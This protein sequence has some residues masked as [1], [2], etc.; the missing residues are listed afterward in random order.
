LLQPSFRI[1]MTCLE[2]I[3]P[4]RSNTLTQFSLK[5]KVVHKYYKT[6]YLH[7]SILKI[8]P[9]IKSTKLLSWFSYFKVQTTKM[10][11]ASFTLK[12]ICCVNGF[13]KFYSEHSVVHSQMKLISNPL[14][15]ATNTIKNKQPLDIIN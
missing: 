10:V 6:L 13:S 8:K 11:L 12:P 14:K 4:T 2:M 15:T 3:S 5:I 1:F 7:I 9:D